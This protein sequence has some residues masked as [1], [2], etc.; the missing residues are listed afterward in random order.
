[1]MKGASD[2]LVL[3][4]VVDR[5]FLLGAIVRAVCSVAAATGWSGLAPCAVDT[6]AIETRSACGV[7]CSAVRIGVGQWRGAGGDLDTAMFVSGLAT[8]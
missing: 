3:V 6:I 4:D 7:G 2:P 8:L 5:C 1:M